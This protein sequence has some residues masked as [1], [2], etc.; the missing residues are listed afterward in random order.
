MDRPAISVVIEK[1]IA[2]SIAARRKGIILLAVALVRLECV[3]W[4]RYGWRWMAIT[5]ASCP[6]RRLAAPPTR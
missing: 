4:G 3:P 1:E 5:T 6:P 2:D